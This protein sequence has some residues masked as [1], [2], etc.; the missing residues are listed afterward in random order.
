MDL[1]SALPEE[2][3]NEIVTYLQEK[4]VLQA[5]LVCKSWEQMFGQSKKFVQKVTVRYSKFNYNKND[6]DALLKS[7]RK[8][9]NLIIGFQ[10]FCIEELGVE[11][12][13]RAI[14]KKFSKSIVKLQTSHDFQRIYELPKLK[15]LKYINFHWNYR[16][17]RYFFSSGLIATCLNVTKLLIRCNTL[18]EKHLKILEEAIK[19]MRNLKTLVL[20]Q[21]AFLKNIGPEDCNFRLEH[22]E[23]E[24]YIP[25]TD[26]SNFLK[27]HQSTLKHIKFS[28]LYPEDIPFI[29]SEFSKLRTLH[30][31]EIPFSRGQ[32]LDIPDIP[33]NS[34]IKN[35][36]IRGSNDNQ[37]IQDKIAE[38]FTKLKNLK[39][40]RLYMLHSRYIPTLFASTTLT[41]VKYGSLAYDV[42]EYQ[43]NYLNTIENIK[44]IPY[45]N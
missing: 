40:V 11:G 41:S 19:N 43:K 21:V 31:I 24:S 33:E 6:I 22:F 23:T 29:F 13:I 35:F 5:S 28:R 38:I 16:D 10:N 18:N 45:S 26:I 30:I 14:L 1:L 17:I 44:L 37:E 27:C 15:E 12:N 3:F 32:L 20:N 25:M 9:Q 2:I 8:Y 42:T 36:Y 34:T 4:D 39:H 7:D